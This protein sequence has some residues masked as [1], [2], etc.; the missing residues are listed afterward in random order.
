MTA[1]EMKQNFLVLYDKVT[2]FAAPGY[3]DSEIQLFLNKAQLQ[4]VKRKYNY[5]GNVY[6]EGFEETE[7]R[8]K[9]LSELVY[10]AELT[11]SDIS[12]SQVGVSPNGVFYDLPNNLLYTLREEVTI[13]SSDT[14]I[15]GNRI[16]VKPITH[17]EY[18]INIKNPFKKPDNNLV[19]R[20][21]FSRET[22]SSNSA[23]RHELVYGNSYTIST[24]HL[25]YLKEPRDIVIDTVA[26]IDSELDES[27]H[28]EIVDIAV[29]IASGITDPQTY[30]IKVNEEKV[31]E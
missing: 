9:D 27:T 26:P 13:S 12:A 15:D 3:E 4:Y 22:A 31:T 6:K 20:L 2:N 21:D 16:A 18:A 17:D 7:K 1:A 10:N 14:C 19:W 5:K 8:R 24:Y 30:Q 28:P 25:R 29:R 23:Q 11:N